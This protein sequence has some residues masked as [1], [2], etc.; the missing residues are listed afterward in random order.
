M[1][2][3]NKFSDIK[4]LPLIKRPVIL[5]VLAYRPT[6]ADL[7]PFFAGKIKHA[8]PENQIIYLAILA[9]I[10]AM[11][12]LHEQTQACALIKG[13]ECYVTG[14]P[15]SKADQTYNAAQENKFLARVVTVL[16]SGRFETEFLYLKSFL[17][18]G[19]T[20]HYDI[21]G[22]KILRLNMKPNDELTTA[23]Q[24]KGL[25]KEEKANI[26]QLANTLLWSR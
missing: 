13:Y 25:T 17:C 15:R 3:S 18:R 24:Q 9:H 2:V 6:Q 12:K 10:T 7:D 11:D 8:T 4:T 1:H 16:K 5:R 14:K 26:I 23:I 21:T 20:M 22:S 19:D